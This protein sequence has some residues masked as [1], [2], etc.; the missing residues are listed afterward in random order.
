[1]HFGKKNSKQIRCLKKKP[2]TKWSSNVEI[3]YLQ[4]YSVILKRLS[5]ATK[6]SFPNDFFLIFALSL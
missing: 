2:A 3:F 5:I 6:L 1:M 4:T